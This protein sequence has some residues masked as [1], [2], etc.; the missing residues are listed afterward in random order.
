MIRDCLSLALAVLMLLA[1][2]QVVHADTVRDD[3]VTLDLSLEKWVETDSATVTVAADLAVKAG[4]FGAARQ[5]VKDDLAKISGKAAWRLT[6]YNRLR[7]EAGFER[8]RIVAEA[9]LPSTELGGLG[10]TV[11]GLG[12]AGRSYAVLGIDFTPTLAEREAAMA[13]LRAE[14]YRSAA[15]ELERLKAVYPDRGYRVATINFQTSGVPRPMPAQMMRVE[16]APK[17]AADGAMA[18][19]SVAQRAELRAS[20][21][22]AA[23]VRSDD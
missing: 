20:V 23:E 3:I 11:K 7:D 19:D 22:F 18:G 6:G 1:A 2:P 21:R 14:I 17:L 9:R 16:S 4:G 8:W 10:G 15:E 13:D 5:A 12:E